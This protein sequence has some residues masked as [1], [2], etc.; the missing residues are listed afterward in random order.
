[1]IGS[2]ITY[3]SVVWWPKTQQTE[4]IVF[5]NG[6]ERLACLCDTETMG[7]ILPLH[8]TLQIET[9]SVTYKLI[10]NQTP[11]SQIHE[12]IHQTLIKELNIGGVTCLPT[13]IM[14]T[15]YNSNKRY[16]SIQP[17]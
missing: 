6:V 4:V 13:D 12:E 5:L 16:I 8:I 1:M 2:L 10:P 17:G 15:K 7:T 14:T 9:K 3:C 11:A